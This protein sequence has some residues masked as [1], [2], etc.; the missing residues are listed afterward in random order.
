MT[1]ASAGAAES[2]RHELVITRMFD[3]PPALVFAAWTDPRHAVKWWGPTHYPAR[4]LEIDARPGG[5]W[6]AC[7]RSVES[8]EDLWHGG[9]FREVL[10]PRRLVFTFAWE[11]EGERGLETLVTIDFAEEGGRTRMRFHQAP[12]LSRDERDG[13]EGGWTST[14]DRFDAHLAYLQAK[15]GK[16]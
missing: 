1:A 6:R 14:F 12:F 11:E 15:T 13:H 5:A 9:V 4:H 3:A 2:P 10:A 8:G 7:L 16:P